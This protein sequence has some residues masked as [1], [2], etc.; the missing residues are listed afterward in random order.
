LVG[1]LTHRAL[2]RVLSRGLHKGAEP[3]IVRDIMKTDPVSVTSST[4]SLEAMDVMRSNQVG[5]LPVVDDG[6]LVGIVTSYDFL[7]ATARLFKEHLTKS[8]G[9]SLKLSAPNSL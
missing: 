4:S 1:L 5:C 2:L 6:Q 7:D 9:T 8:Q 3:L